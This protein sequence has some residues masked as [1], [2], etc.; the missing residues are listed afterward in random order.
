MNNFALF[1]KMLE[2]LKKI[3]KICFNDTGFFEMCKL[4]TALCIIDKYFW[5][6]RCNLARS[7]KN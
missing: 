6:I 7:E 3:V 4:P 5:T 1:E 2:K